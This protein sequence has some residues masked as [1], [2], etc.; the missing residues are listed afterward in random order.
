[1]ALVPRTG[2][3]VMIIQATGEVSSFTR[4]ILNIYLVVIILTLARL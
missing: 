1:M 2:W 4:R 3:A